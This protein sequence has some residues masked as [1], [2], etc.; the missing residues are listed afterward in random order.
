MDVYPLQ[1]G[2]VD[3]EIYIK[4]V[5]DFLGESPTRGIDQNNI[6]TK[7]P[8]AFLKT[9]DFGNQPLNAMCQEHL[10]NHL[11]FSFIA[12]ID[13][14]VL[15]DISSRTDLSSVYA[16]KR[17]KIMVLLS[18]TL[19]QWKRGIIQASS[20]FALTETRKL[21]NEIHTRFEA[22]G[23]GEIWNDYE[24]IPFRDGTVICKGR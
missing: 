5:K 11:F 20:K 3:W 19:Y 7:N 4:V 15:A 16:E 14:F 13:G 10:Y 12:I 21:I 8:I 17:N 18:G 1:M 9:L 22:A 6:D 23:F 2:Q 24:F